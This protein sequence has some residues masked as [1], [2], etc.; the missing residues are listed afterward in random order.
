MRQDTVSHSFPIMARVRANLIVEGG[1]KPLPFPV[2]VKDMMGWHS[3]RLKRI[4]LSGRQNNA[5]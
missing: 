5:S 3:L 1:K 2:S 4:V